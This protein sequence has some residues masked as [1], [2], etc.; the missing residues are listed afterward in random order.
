MPAVAK[1]RN[2]T[3]AELFQP[4]DFLLQTGQEF[5]CMGTIHLRM[6]KLERYGQLVPK[7][8]FSVFAPDDERII[9][10]AAIHADSPVDFGIDNGRGADNHAISR[11]VVVPAR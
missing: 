9:E 3:A 1:E 4:V 6:V 7:P 10:H 11:Q 5:P 8:L 2:A